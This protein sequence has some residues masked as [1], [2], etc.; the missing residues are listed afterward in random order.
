MRVF[1]A[2]RLGLGLGQEPVPEPSAVSAIVKDSFGRGYPGLSVK[3]AHEGTGEFI[4]RGITNPEG[5]VKIDVPSSNLRV[6]IEPETGFFLKSYPEGDV[7]TSLPLETKGVVVEA[8]RRN[9]GWGH[10]AEFVV[11]PKAIEDYLTTTNLIITAVVAGG[12]WYFFLR[13]KEGE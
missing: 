1:H 9:W 2:Q 13:K 8:L 11:Y 5:R 12:I 6:A 7:R 3:A 10:S 4:G